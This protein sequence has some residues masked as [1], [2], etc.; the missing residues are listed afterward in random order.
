M[1]KFSDISQLPLPPG[2]KLRDWQGQFLL[3]FLNKCV[4]KNNPFFLLSAAPAAGKTIGQFCAAYTLYKMGLVNWIIVVVP[5]DHLRTQVGEEVDKVFALETCNDPG[6]FVVRDFH[7]EVITYA[8]LAANPN[9]Y[10]ERC[11][12]FGNRV[13][14][15]GIHHLG[16]TNS[17]GQAFKTAFCCASYRL[18]TSGTPF[19]TGNEKILSGWINYKLDQEGNDI[20]APDYRYG[21]AEAVRYNVVRAVIFP[22][23]EGEFTWQINGRIHITSFKEATSKKELTY[24]LATALCPDGAWV[25]TILTEANSQLMEIRSES[26]ADA[27]GILFCMDIPHAQRCAKVLESITGVYLW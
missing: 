6:H 7:G 26:R 9:I 20:S 18:F 24:A 13:M 16:D 5:T 10:K 4:A 25:D 14:V 21:Y 15:V 11:E 3:T 8:Q 23:Y 22:A 1:N 2:L 19:R 12:R 17:W 27:A